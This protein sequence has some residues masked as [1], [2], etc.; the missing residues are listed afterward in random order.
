MMAPLV[1]NPQIKQAELLRP[2]S[3]WLYAYIW[4]FTII[5]P[6]FFAFYSTPDLYDTYIGAQEWTTVW[7]GAIISLQSLVWLSTHWSVNLEGRFTASKAQSV[8]NAEL[9]K[10]I[11]IANAGT[12]EICKLVRDKVRMST[13]N[14]QALC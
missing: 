5:W 12:S 14:Y 6:I 3:F 8:E 13:Y 4:P 9:I 7:C 1:D 11:P 10:V 2:L